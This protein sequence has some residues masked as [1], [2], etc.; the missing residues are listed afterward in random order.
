MRR[1]KE[2]D[3]TSQLTNGI[4]IFVSYLARQYD[5]AIEQGNRTIELYPGSMLAYDWLGATYQKRGHYDQANAAY[6]K[7]KE[8]PGASQNELAAYQVHTRSPVFE[9]TGRRNS[10]RRNGANRLTPVGCPGFMRTWER[11]SRCWNFSIEVPCNIAADRT[12]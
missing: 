5:P 7:S 6:L 3:P 12:P 9:V 2:L 1:A 8:L 10:R 11:K 4:G